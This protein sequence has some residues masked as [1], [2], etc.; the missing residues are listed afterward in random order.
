MPLCC[1]QYKDI[2]SPEILLFVN[3][4]FFLEV[5]TQS[6]VQVLANFVVQTVNRHSQ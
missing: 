6:Y 2:D 1:C 4:T 3:L 5:K